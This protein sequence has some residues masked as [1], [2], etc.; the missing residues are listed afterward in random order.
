MK[1]I[2]LKSLVDRTSN[3]NIDDIYSDICKELGIN[4]DKNNIIKQIESKTKNSKT[5]L[6]YSIPIKKNDEDLLLSM[7]KRLNIVEQNLKEANLKLKKKDEEIIKL[8][9]KIKELEKIKK[10]KE[11]EKENSNITCENCIQLNKIIE[12]QNEYITK[13]YNFMKEN[14]ILI[15]KSIVDPKSQEVINKKLKDLQNE[16]NELNLENEYE[17]NEYDKSLLPKTIDI[18]VLERRIDEM[19]AIIYEEQGNNAQFESEDGKI[20]KLK[21]KKEILI[22]FYKN[23]LIIEGYQFFPYES[24]T[25]QKIIQDIIDGY[26][27]YILHDRYPHGVLM[28]IENH[29]KILYE[30]N[31][32]KNIKNLNDPG[33][34]TYM[35]PKEFV[36]IFPNKIIKNGNI[37]NIKEDMEKILNINKDESKNKDNSKNEENEFNLYDEKNKEIKDEDLCKLKIKVVTVDKIINIKIPKNKHINELFDFVKK[38]VNDNLKKI[39]S[40]LKINNINDYGFIMTFPFKILFYDKNKNK[41]NTLD[42][43]GLYPSLFITF[44]VISKYQQK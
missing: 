28:K 10:E 35:S 11:K 42:K 9:I 36:N 14:G 6:K 37:L 8:N 30:P 29:V 25:S 43:C 3:T 27:P 22:S 18:K 7:T 40:T 31:I 21:Q 34:Q 33:E 17:N 44:D 41:E 32:N 20:F 15:S 1:K 13:L 38:Y 2:K 19:N 26:S 24:E 23:G 4:N 5:P 39:S 16:L 12:Q